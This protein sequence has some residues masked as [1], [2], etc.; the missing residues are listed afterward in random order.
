MVYS[1]TLSFAWF[2]FL[3]VFSQYSQPGS[4]LKSVCLP[5]LSY[6][7]NSM[8]IYIL[9]FS[10]R[11]ENCIFVDIQFYYLPIRAQHFDRVRVICISG[12]LFSALS[13]AY[14]AWN[15][16]VCLFTYCAYKKI[17][18][19]IQLELRIFVYIFCYYHLPILS[20][21]ASRPIY[22]FFGLRLLSP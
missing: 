12:S 14:A 20:L 21:R 2:A 22:D 6:K 7:K 19:H 18:A 9:D 17:A 3:A 8:P 11:A 1:N 4:T 16:W 15:S 13:H 10:A 5:Y